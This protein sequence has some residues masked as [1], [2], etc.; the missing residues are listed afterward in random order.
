MPNPY[1]PTCKAGLSPTFTWPSNPNAVSWRIY[2]TWNKVSPVPNRVL[3]PADVVDNG[4]TCSY[5]PTS[6]YFPVPLPNGS[7]CTWWLETH[8]ANGSVIDP[9]AMK[10][11]AAS[12]DSTTNTDFNLGYVDRF[13][14]TGCQYYPA[15]TFTNAGRRVIDLSL[16]YS[17]G[18]LVPSLCKGFYAFPENTLTNFNISDLVL[19][20]TRAVKVSMQL[21][22]SATSTVDPGQTD[23][24]GF[25]FAYYGSGIL[26][27]PTGVARYAVGHRIPIEI[28]V[29]VGQD[30]YGDTQLVALWSHVANGIDVAATNSSNVTGRAFNACITGYYA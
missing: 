1:Q 14:A 9:G 8:L 27:V 13:S 2:L 20:T 18:I 30:Q 29:P 6:A 15:T 26:N 19:G 22:S 25:D 5:T 10:F 3:V 23:L 11:W 17:G 12:V 16:Q 4:V 24:L 21:I 28:T 7:Y